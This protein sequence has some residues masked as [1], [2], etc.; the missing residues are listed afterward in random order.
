MRPPCDQEEAPMSNNPG[1]RT[2][3]HSSALRKRMASFMLAHEQFPV[4]ELIGLGMAAEEAGF[5]A[6][7]TSD[8]FQPWQA[9][10]GHSGAAWVTLG[11]LGQ[12]T[13]KIWMGPT[14]TC[15]T[16]RYNPAVVAEAFATLGQLY[17]GRVFLGL[18]SGEALN[19]QAATGQW[20]AWRERWDR[21]VEAVDIIRKLWT[22]N[23]V[24]HQG[25]H[26]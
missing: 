16:L 3:N 22:G 15:P 25:R 24:K 20:P 8:H 17:P 26:Y 5:D 18:G 1:S 21:L 23:P 12:R 9:N 7:A 14:V 10:E 2:D 19:E 11:A 4:A 13:K 6:L